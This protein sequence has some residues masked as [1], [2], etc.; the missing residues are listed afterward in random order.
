[1]SA[2][3]LIHIGYPKAGSTFLQEWFRCHPDLQYRPG[4]LAGF[5]NVYELGRPAASVCRYYVTSF[6]GLSTPHESAGDLRLDFDGITA[7]QE[8][9]VKD[10]QARVCARLQT[11]F[12]DARILIVTRG[13][14]SMI[15]SAYSQWVRMGARRRLKEMCNDLALR[16]EQD[17]Y[18]YY[19]YDYVVRL[20]RD[21]FGEDNVIV[22]PYELLRDDQAKFV[23]ELE[24][25]LDLNHYEIKLG[26]INPSLSPAELYWYPATS[27]VVS[28]VVSRLGSPLS[29]PIYSWYVNQTLRNRFHFLIKLLDL[30]APGR[31]ITADNFPTEILSLCESKA[32]LLE[33]NVLYAPY[34]DEYLWN[35]SRKKMAPGVGTARIETVS[36]STSGDR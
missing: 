9:P 30:V 3:H 16:L 26:R 10:N 33:Q 36:L 29:K 13:F 27:R 14:R 28:S 19:D 20:Y 25:R 8:D 32:T 24:E 35:R 2:R 5:H 15:M 31:T 17:A 11:L 1:M 12:P 6:E 34:A 23:S 7:V 21:A 18:H 22:L 4:G